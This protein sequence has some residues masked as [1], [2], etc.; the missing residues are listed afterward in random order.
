MMKMRVPFFKISLV[1]LATSIT[2]YVAWVN[3]VDLFHDP[4]GLE[5]SYPYMIG[6]YLCFF[7]SILF[8]AM[9]LI[10]YVLRKRN[11]KNT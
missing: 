7:A 10:R 5:K 3:Q 1:L 4:I 6:F 8:G 2:V 11:E 9:G